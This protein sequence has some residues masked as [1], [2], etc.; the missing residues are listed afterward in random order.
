VNPLEQQKSGSAGKFLPHIR[1]SIRS[2]DGNV[3]VS[4]GEQG[5]IFVSGASIFSGYVDMA[6]AS[7]FEIFDG[8]KWYKTGDLGY[9]DDD[10]FLFITGRLK[11]FVKIA[12]EMISLPAIE[13]TL[14]EKYGNPDITTLAVEARET[15]G[16]VTIVVFATFD[17]AVD[18]L[19]EYIHTHGLSN[20]VKIAR[21]DRVD[22]IPVLGTG[23]T[24]YKILKSKI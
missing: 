2:I 20:L 21:V 23:K 16:D 4:T 18:E 1:S 22:L 13:S 7:P 24:D 3:P 19:N 17:V 11:R 10:G 15:D 9:I 8:I 12:G 5:M 14:L 6:L